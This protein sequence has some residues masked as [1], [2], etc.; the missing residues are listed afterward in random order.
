MAD[1]L[2]N[3][4]FKEGKL[5]KIHIRELMARTYIGFNDW[6]KAT[7]QDVA[8][9]LTL[10]LDLSV[11][12]H[13]DDV[14]DTVDYKRLKQRI[15]NLVEKGRFLLIEKMASD[16]AHICLEDSLVERVDVLVDKLS[17]LRFAKSVAVE[18]SRSKKDVAH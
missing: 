9:T 17:A 12:G 5:D 4:F 14:K 16:I 3:Q 8:I 13:T 2:H 15:L 6:E 10:H 1:S 7:R 18:I 11:A